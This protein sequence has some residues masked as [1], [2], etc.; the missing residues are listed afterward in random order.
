[1][2]E[3]TIVYSAL[4]TRVINVPV[5]GDLFDVNGVFIWKIV[6]TLTHS[7]CKSAHFASSWPQNSNL[8]SVELYVIDQ[9]KIVPHLKTEGKDTR[10]PNLL[11]QKNPKNMVCI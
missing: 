9:H 7:L 10:S 6:C 4:L 5:G 8:F 11:Y 3:D 2:N 1:M